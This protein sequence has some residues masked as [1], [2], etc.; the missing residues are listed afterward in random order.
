MQGLTN[1]LGDNVPRGTLGDWLGFQGAAGLGL[2]PYGYGLFYGIAPWGQ[3]AHML[4]RQW[5]WNGIGGQDHGKLLPK[6]T[7]PNS[8]GR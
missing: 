4:N 1:G 3:Q 6:F 8:P 7:W 5:G 2:G